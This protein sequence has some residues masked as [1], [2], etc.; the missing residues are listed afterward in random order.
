VGDT[1]DVGEAIGTVEAVGLRIT[2][3]RDAQGVLWYIRNGEIIRVGNKSQGW[4]VVIVD[5]P[6]GYSPVEEATAV[7]RA[8]A[9]TLAEDP[10]YAADFIEP[11]EVLGV[12]QVT[13]DGAVVR[14]TAKTPAEA[15]IR[16]VRE[17][18]R[19]LAEA[20][21]AAGI[22]AKIAASRAFTRPGPSGVPG[23]GNGGNGEPGPSGAT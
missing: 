19:R 7:L 16:V 21:D 6:I 20:L 18:R 22:S 23:A 3:V 4:A 17:L 2:T 1:V 13:V 8:A 11:P 10:E 5:M 12:E 9:A 14:T 15:Q